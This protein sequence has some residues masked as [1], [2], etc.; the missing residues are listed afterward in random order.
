MG[1][2]WIG[3]R[4]RRGTDPGATDAVGGPTSATGRRSEVNRTIDLG[5]HGWTER[6]ATSTRMAALHE[7]L[8][9]RRAR[10][11]AE[12]ELTRLRER[13]WSGE[14]VVEEGRLGM[15]YWEHH[16]ADPYA[17]LSLLPG[18]SLDDAAA[19]RRRIAQECHPDRLVDD[20]HA[21]DALRRM[22]AA[23]A[24]YDRL[25]RALRTA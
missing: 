18:A 5:G 16:E 6:L 4:A 14:R 9:T 3:R 17:V 10:E 12:R 1:I 7:E 13:H 8:R 22:V 21:D 11:E 23:N 25:R 20:H 19:A 2:T 24:A 15:D